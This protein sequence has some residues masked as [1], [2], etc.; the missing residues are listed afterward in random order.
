MCRS[1]PR[2]I[3]RNNVQNNYLYAYTSGLEGGP[4]KVAADSIGGI[5]I[6]AM[7]GLQAYI[8]W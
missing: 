8:V 7:I 6:F 1:E 5:L 3:D 2:P 4:I